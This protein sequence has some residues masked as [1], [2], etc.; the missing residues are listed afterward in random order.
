MKRFDVYKYV[1][2][3]YSKD[4]VELF[5]ED[6]GQNGVDLLFSCE[7]EDQVNDLLLQYVELQPDVGVGG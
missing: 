1:E 2:Q 6:H 4:V 5:E 7:D 3:N